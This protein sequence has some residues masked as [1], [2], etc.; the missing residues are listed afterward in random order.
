MLLAVIDSVNAGRVSFLVSI[1]TRSDGS[2]MF[3]MVNLVS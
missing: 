3:K 1:G 2:G